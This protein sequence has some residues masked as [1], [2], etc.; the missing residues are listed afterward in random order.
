M[1]ILHDTI[2]TLCQNGQ[3]QIKGVCVSVACSRPSGF[4]LGELKHCNHKLAS[5]LGWRTLPDHM[6]QITQ[7]V[8]C[9]IQRCTDNWLVPHQMMLWQLTGAPTKGQTFNKRLTCLTKHHFWY[10]TH[11]KGSDMPH[12]GKMGKLWS[13]TTTQLTMQLMIDDTFIQ[14]NE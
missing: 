12:Y 13:L 11:D 5:M 10:Q 9:H 4:A 14:S 7:C 3:L 2:T 1:S 8:T 6:W